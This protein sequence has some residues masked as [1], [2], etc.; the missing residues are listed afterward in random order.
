MRPK[1]MEM[2]ARPRFRHRDSWR[3]G[4]P[5]R[6]SET[7]SAIIP[8]QSTIQRKPSTCTCGG[9][10]PRCRINQPLQAKLV[11]GSPNDKYEEEAD[12]VSERVMRIPESMIQ[13]QTVPE[14]EEPLQAKSLT[15]Q[16]TPLAQRQPVSEEEEEEPIQT[17][18]KGGSRSSVTSA[19]HEQIQSLRGGGRPLTM[20]ERAFFEPRI[21]CDFSHVRLHTDARAQETARALRAHAYTMGQDVMFGKGEY[22]FVIKEDQKLLAHELTH[23]VQQSHC[24]GLTGVQTKQKLSSG[25]TLDPKF[26]LELILGP[27]PESQSAAVDQAQL[28]ELYKYLKRIRRVAPALKQLVK[29]VLEAYFTDFADDVWEASKKPLAGYT[30]T[31]YRARPSMKKARRLGL[32]ETTGCG[33][34][35]RFLGS[36]VL[37]FSG[38]HF[39]SPV[40]G[41]PGEFDSL[42]IKKLRVRGRPA[43]FERVKLI[44]VSSCSVL[45]KSAL[46]TFRKKFPNAYILGWYA[47]ASWS[48]SS[49]M[50]RFLDKLSEDLLLEDP[51][52]MEKVLKLEEAYV[53]NLEKE[54]IKLRSEDGKKRTKWGLGYATPDGKVKY[55]VRKKGGKWIWKIES[56][57]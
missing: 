48:Q 25:Y 52:D 51:S 34:V 11:I 36:D 15:S 24:H 12:Q 56:R 37:F 1:A 29:N 45:R 7:P 55:L 39:G 47:G 33:R 42:D 21:G 22:S 23:V 16:I 43:I 50:A 27:K 13:R 30:G 53:E 8:L 49:M 17:K 46:P 2:R 38:H 41:G 4:N 35:K 31:R 44:M 19:M 5:D 26:D 28:L 9:A 3:T 32:S 6:L 14:E 40:D 20:A 10:C 18:P 57:K 54:G